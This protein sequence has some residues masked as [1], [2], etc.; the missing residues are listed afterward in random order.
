MRV[1]NPIK[2]AKTCSFHSLTTADCRFAG[3]ELL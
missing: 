2:L 3:W 1:I